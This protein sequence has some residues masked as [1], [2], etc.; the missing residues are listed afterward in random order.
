MRETLIESV[1]SLPA[2]EITRGKG[3][4]ETHQTHERGAAMSSE[5]APFLDEIGPFAPLL[6]HSR[7]L[8]DRLAAEFSFRVFR[9]IHCLDELR[10]RNRRLRRGRNRR[11][12][13]LQQLSDLAGQ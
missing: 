5:A 8:D 6:A 1:F 10:F 11:A 13:P 3:H 9:G 7:S 2:R 12:T 4:H